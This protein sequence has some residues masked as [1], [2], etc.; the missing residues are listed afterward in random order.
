MGSIGGEK[1]MAHAAERAVDAS[2]RV[3]GIGVDCELVSRFESMPYEESRHFYSGV[4]TEEETG[5]CLSSANP[6]RRFAGRFAARE[7]VVKAAGSRAK[8]SPLDVEIVRGDSGEPHVRFRREFAGLEDLIFLVSISHAGE[9]AVAVALACQ[10]T[11]T[12]ETKL[13]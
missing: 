13:A 4:F 11:P 12:A 7:A 10:G 1:L 9:Y 6:Y 2:D 8:L 5:Y 3:V